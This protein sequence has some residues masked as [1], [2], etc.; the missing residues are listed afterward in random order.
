MDSS[1]LAAGAPYDC[2]SIE[3]LDFRECVRRRPGMYFG[4]LRE[5][6]AIHTLVWGPVENSVAQHRER[7][8]FRV[9]VTLHR[10]GSVTIEDDGPGIP[11]EMWRGQ[12]VLELWLTRCQ[13]GGCGSREGAPL[14]LG[15]IFLAAVNAGSE[16]L[17]IEV[18]WG[19]RL[20]RQRYARATPLGPVEALGPAEGTGTRITLRPDGLIFPCTDFDAR[21][22]QDRLREIA[23][24]NPGLRVEFVDERRGGARMALR[25][26]GLCEW[27]GLLTEGQ[28][29][30][31]AMP[32][33]CRG[34]VGGIEV[35]AAL[36][37]V[38]APATRVRSFANQWPTPEGGTH[39]LGLYAGIARALREAE[40]RWGLGG[41]RRAKLTRE[42][43][44][45]GL[46]AVVSV[47][48]PDPRFDQLRVRL[49][50]EDTRAAVRDVVA[51]GM[52]GALAWRVQA[53]EV[54]RRV[55]G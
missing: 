28:E 20:Y 1:D 37:W 27:V 17:V 7:R 49:R 9:S 16:E 40:A 41:G 14:H 25:T 3:V 10:S 22:V 18:R 23:F 24:L 54:W 11:V 35:E 51:R 26:S 43:M 33:V 34:E 12:P 29:G 32:I 36:R 52:G 8:C 31:P 5:G 2:R 6:A 55:T 53:E 4:D 21:H 13:P 42:V 47:H 38:W 39:A 45:R 19:G 50:N 44:G 15:G 48:H 46:V 30:F